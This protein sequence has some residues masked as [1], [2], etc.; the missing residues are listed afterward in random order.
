VVYIW[1]LVRREALRLPTSPDKNCSD[2]KY[3]TDNVDRGDKEGRS[4]YERHHTH[5]RAHDWSPL[6]VQ[7]R[8]STGCVPQV[9]KLPQA[10]LG[11]RKGRSKGGP[12]QHHFIL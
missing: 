8:S 4:Q 5:N 9:S 2:Q 10:D 11:Q 12:L 7:K 1:P 3:G 6:W